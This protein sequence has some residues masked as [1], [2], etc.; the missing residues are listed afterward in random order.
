MDVFRYSWFLGS[1]IYVEGASELVK[2]IERHGHRCQVIVNANL[3]LFHSDPFSYLLNPYLFLPTLALSSSSLQNSLV[4][5]TVKYAAGGQSL[6]SHPVFLLTSFLGRASLSLFLLSFLLHIDLSNLVLLLSISLL[7]ISDPHSRLA[8]PRPLIANFRHALPLF[9]EFILYTSILSIASTII[10]GGTQWMPQTWGAT[11]VSFISSIL[12]TL[13]DR[14]PRLTL[15]DL[16]PNTGL[17]WYFFT[18]MFD[19]FRPFFLVVFSVSSCARKPFV[20]AYSY[21]LSLRFTFSSMWYLCASS[22]SE[23]LCSALP[24]QKLICADMIL[25]IRYSSF[26]EC[27][28]HSRHTRRFLILVF[29]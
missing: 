16:T 15:P 7:L 20:L 12:D 29:S 19:H 27:S 4:L 6:S 2:I 9:G 21:F 24:C 10:V 3:S 25:Y 28:E 23:P 18:E 22:F 17:W 11:Y 13:P 5:L 1:C 26:W 14:S 8:S